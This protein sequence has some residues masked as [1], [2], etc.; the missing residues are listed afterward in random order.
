M[1][2]GMPVT[3]YYKPEAFLRYLK[4]NTVRELLDFIGIDNKLPPKLKKQ[5]RAGYL[6]TLFD[7]FDEATNKQIDAIFREVH[8]MG[9][10]S[11]I[12]TLLNLFKNPHPNLAKEIQNKSNNYNQALYI[13]MKDP[14]LFKRAATLSY[15]DEKKIKAQRNGLKQVP[16]N[17]LY[18][19]KEALAKAI[20]QYLMTTDGR[21]ENCV[22]ETHDHYEGKVLF[23]ALPEDYV[24]PD[25]YYD[26]NRQ[27]V[28]ATKKPS[29][30]ILFI[31]YPNEGKLELACKGGKK[32]EKALFNMFN[33]VVL[34]DE[35]PILEN[36]VIYNL[37]KFFEP[38]FK[39]IT[40]PEHDIREVRV[41]RIKFQHR[42]NPEYKHTIELNAES[43]NTPF[44]TALAKTNVNPDE[45]KIM[46]V[47]VNL[48]FPGKGRRG[49][50]TMELTA[51]DKCSLNESQLHQKAREYISYWGIEH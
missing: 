36:Q 45:M 15:Y 12:M 26:E 21:G 17:E 29:F 18:A 47:A 28:K 46:H 9:N 33:A 19:Q 4:Y 41:K 40:K 13:Y 48:K 24:R 32:R 14:D 8:A 38:D 10:E 37:E 50:V 30:E 49:S 31:Y 43:R 1:I 22:V 23:V 51:P 16:V 2:L 6:K 27:L 5:S 3:R 11:G 7:N 39:L 35:T 25:L 34:R 20:S 42:H 44:R